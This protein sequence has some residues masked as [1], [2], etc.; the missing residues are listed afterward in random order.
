MLKNIVISKVR[1][2]LLEQFFFNPLEQYHVRGLV[3][4]LD[5]EINAIRR[6]LLNLESAGILKS[7]K[8]G[9]KIVYVVNYQNQFVYDLRDIVIKN[10]SIGMKFAKVAKEVGNVNCVL[11]TNAFLTNSYVDENDIDFLFIGDIDVRVL[12]NS[13]K[14]IESDLQKELRYTAL[15]LVDFDFGKKKRTPVI[16]N[17]I[18]KDFVVIYGSLRQ[19]IM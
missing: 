5:E 8:Q 11:A 7:E 10:S 4:I 15:T 12:A 18:S 1:I 16:I 17:A 2:K 13:M 9:N 19:M 3:R 14:Q 6:E